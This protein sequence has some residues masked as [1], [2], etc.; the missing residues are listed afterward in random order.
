MNQQ[1][2]ADKFPSLKM[3]SLAV[4]QTTPFSPQALETLCSVDTIEGST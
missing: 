1:G 3:L 2:D 4:L